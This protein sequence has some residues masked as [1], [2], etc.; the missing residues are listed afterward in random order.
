MKGFQCPHCGVGFNIDQVNGLDDYIEDQCDIARKDGY[1][2]GH[3]D[4][5][6][7]GYQDAMDGHPGPQESRDADLRLSLYR[8]IYAGDIGAAQDAADLMAMVDI[9]RELIWSARGK[10][11]CYVG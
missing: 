10:G 11:V 2:D 7:S 6:E 4:G 8:A 3:D 1:D 9:D 5:E